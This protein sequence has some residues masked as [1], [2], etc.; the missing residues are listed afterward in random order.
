MHRRLGKFRRKLGETLLD[1]GA[2]AVEYAVLLGLIVLACVSV[3]RSLG[4]WSA[5][6]FA[7][8]TNGIPV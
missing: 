5:A 2:T 4:F 8:L 7:E 1:E 6:V 3:I